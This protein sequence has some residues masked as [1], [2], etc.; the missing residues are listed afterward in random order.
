MKNIAQYRIGDPL[1]AQT[2][3]GPMARADLRKTVHEQ[4]QRSIEKG[5]KLLQG[6][7]IHANQPGFYYP[8]TLL[9]DVK[10]GMPAFDEELFGPVIALIAAE[11]E[12]EALKLANQT[13]YGLGA[14]IFTRDEVRGEALATEVLEAGTCFVNGKV[15]SDPRVP[16]GGIKQS[17]FGRELAREGLLAF[18]N[19]KTVGIG[20]A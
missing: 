7:V 9:T 19:M 8:I 4:V 6:G 11:N 10:P 3:M 13:V 16:F 17:G 12:D 18:V 14:S 5:A 20:Y 15:S 1:D 2:T